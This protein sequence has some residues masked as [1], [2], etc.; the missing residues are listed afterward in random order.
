MRCKRRRRRPGREL[1]EKANHADCRAG[2]R[3]DECHPEFDSR[4]ARLFFQLRNASQRKQRNLAHRNS[5]RSREHRMRQLMKQQRGEEQKPGR[6]RH[7]QDHTVSPS[8]IARMKFRVEGND[9]Q[10]A[11]NKPAVVKRR[12]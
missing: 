8:R 1:H 11:D 2:Q 3:P 4:A 6:D 5:V 9:D 12:E 7:R 10:Q